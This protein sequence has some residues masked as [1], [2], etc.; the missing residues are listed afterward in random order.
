MN[1]INATSMAFIEVAC[2]ERKVL[3]ADLRQVL[4]QKSI[5]NLVFIFN[6]SILVTADWPTQ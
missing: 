5:P 6:R 3:L 1:T 4:R 2:S